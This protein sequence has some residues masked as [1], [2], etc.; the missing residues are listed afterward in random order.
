MRSGLARG[1]LDDEDDEDDANAAAID[2]IGGYI[3]SNGSDIP[4]SDLLCLGRSHSSSPVLTQANVSAPAVPAG[5]TMVPRA[6]FASPA[7]LPPALPPKLTPLNLHHHTATQAIVT[8]HA[9]QTAVGGPPLTPTPCSPKAKS[10][11]VPKSGL[12]IFAK[13]W[14]DQKSTVDNVQ[15]SYLY[16]ADWSDGVFLKRNETRCDTSG[17][18]V[19]QKDGNN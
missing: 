3:S 6:T 18:P 1:H 19:E 13:R 4:G 15:K 17:N 5:A 8:A 10:E 11:S 2:A 14:P 7:L 12:E 16:S 9:N